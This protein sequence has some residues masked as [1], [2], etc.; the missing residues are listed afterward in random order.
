[1][2]FPWTHG[3]L[4]HIRWIWAPSSGPARCFCFCAKPASGRRRIEQILTDPAQR[5]QVIAM[6]DAMVPARPRLDGVTNDLAVQQQLG[7][8]RSHG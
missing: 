6:A 7:E 5:R 8:L 2:P 1:M 4:T 3:E